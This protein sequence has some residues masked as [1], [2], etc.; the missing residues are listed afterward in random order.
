MSRVSNIPDD[1]SRREGESDIEY[2]IRLVA[3]K[4]E[5]PWSRLSWADIVDELGLNV[6]PDSLRK[7]NDTPLGGYAVAKHYKSLPSGQDSAYN[8]ELEKIK[9]RS[10]RLDANRMLRETAR[11]ELFIEEII[12]VLRTLPPIEPPEILSSKKLTDESALLLVSDE[13]Y[14]TEFEIK[15]LCGEVLNAYS[16]DIFRDR[17]WHLRDEVIAKC[18]MLSQN[19]LTVF[20]LGDSLDGIL[21]LSQLMSLREGVVD[22]C[23]QYADFMA[24]WLNSLSEYLRIDYYATEGNH[25]MLRLLTG[26]KPD[27]PHE[28]MQKI[29]NHIIRIRLENNP[30]ITIH[31]NHTKHIFAEIQGFTVLGVHGEHQNGPQAKNNY[32]NV[33]GHPID[34]MCCGH[35]HHVIAE[36]TGI[37]KGIINAGSIMGTNDYALRMNYAASPSATL[38]VLEKEKGKTQEHTIVL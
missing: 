33:Y 2:G 10:M 11:T 37:R 35:R 21:H 15:G 23:I 29:I 20:S 4:K 26:K 22:S 18:D 16:P 38:L 14:G 9:L 6:N 28:N 17:M 7:A 19:H 3:D 25:T 13:H 34:Y 5:N 36:E 32:A 31:D 30:N 27:F 8:Y 1:L 12:H 24:W